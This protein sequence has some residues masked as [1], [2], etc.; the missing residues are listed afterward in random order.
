MNEFTFIARECPYCQ[1]GYLCEGEPIRK[2]ES[3]SFFLLCDS[4]EFGGK[5][6]AKLRVDVDKCNEL[7]VTYRDQVVTTFTYAARVLYCPMCGRKL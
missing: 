6:W 5:Y 7:D 1:I 4:Q 3:S 2:E